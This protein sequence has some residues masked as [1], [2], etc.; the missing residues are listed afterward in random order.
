MEVSVKNTV[1]TERK[2]TLGEPTVHIDGQSALGTRKMAVSLTIF[3]ETG[4]IVGSLRQVYSGQMFNDVYSN[5]YMSD[6][7]LVARVLADSSATVSGE[8]PVDYLNK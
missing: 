2:G 8:M 5:N 3:N 1:T 4:K 6:K 7:D